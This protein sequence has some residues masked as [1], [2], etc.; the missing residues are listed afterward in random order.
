MVSELRDVLI[1]YRDGSC[2]RIA[3]EEVLAG[4]RREGNTIVVGYDDFFNPDI[5]YEYPGIIDVDL[6]D[7]KSIYK[8]KEYRG[9][10]IPRLYPKCSI[11]ERGVD[12]L[13]VQRYDG[14]L[15]KVVHAFPAEILL[16]IL[17]NPGIALWDLASLEV[18]AT[19][20][21]HIDLTEDEAVMIIELTAEAIGFYAYILDVVEIQFQ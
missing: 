17:N 12:Y 7:N 16:N 4:F 1:I 3:V 2:K 14:A 5:L 19:S 20:K 21:E 15:I 10:R 11:V 8:F 13:L 9:S 6:R 18:L